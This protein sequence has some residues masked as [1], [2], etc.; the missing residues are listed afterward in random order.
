MLIKK[1]D[2][3]CFGAVTING[4]TKM[5]IF[6]VCLFDFLTTQHDAIANVG[7]VQINAKQPMNFGT[8]C[9][10]PYQGSESVS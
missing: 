10:K 6:F 3:V 5:C 1:Y 4:Y 8:N 9:P 2:L 7:G